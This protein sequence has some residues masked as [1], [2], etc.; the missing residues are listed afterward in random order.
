MSKSL[1]KF[2]ILA[3]SALITSCTREAEN[4]VPAPVPESRT[5]YYKATVQTEVDTRATLGN[6]FSYRFETGDRVYME[7][8]DGNMYGFLSM[9]D[10]E[11]VGENQ[12]VFEGKLTCVGNY[13]PS[14]DTAVK[15]VLVS[16]DDELHTITN[17]K[18]DEVNYPQNKWA[19]SLEE[20]VLHLSHFTGS[21]I[22]GATQFS[23]NQQSC[24]L[25][26]NIRIKSAEAPVNSTV[27]ASL[28]NNQS[29]TPL[30]TASIT[31]QTAGSA[32]FVF[33]FQGGETSLSD[34]VLH[35]EWGDSEKSFDIKDKA[36]AANN[37]YSVF[38]DTREYRGFH[39]RAKN[40]GTN[41]T[42]KYTDG[43]IEYSEDFGDNWTKY[44]GKT[45]QLNA[46][47]VV[48]FRGNRT[49]CNCKGGTQLFTANDIC[50]I[51]G[52]IASLLGYP[53]TLPANAFRSAFSF[54]EISD[55]YAENSEKNLPVATGTVNWVDIDSGDPLILPATTGANCYMEM[56]LGC[57][58]LKTAPDLPAT[59]LADKCYFRMFYGCSSLTSIPTLPSVVTW[60]GTSNRQRYCFQM[61]QYCTGIKKLEEALF[62]G[63]MTLAPNCFEDMFA[64][65]TG[66]TSVIPGLLPATTLA[67]HCY[68]GMFQDTRFERAPDL[69]AT[70][71]VECCYRYMFNG[72]TKLK[73]I[74]CL[75][76][77]PAPNNQNDASTKDWVGNIS[78]SGTFI[79]NN[80]DAM[81]KSWV[82]GA[83]YGIPSGWTAYQVKD[84][85]E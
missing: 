64:H 12:A 52:E 60:N 50:Y 1:F 56:F 25:N 46:N 71:L 8:E 24:F 58:K 51:A 14:Y 49:D 21:G 66:L 83:V 34:A 22:F 33:A 27:T 82:T 38:R 13:T 7:S 18:V 3:V 80:D 68:R 73:Y 16:P 63:T 55:S 5:I 61:F 59:V 35:V 9:S 15:L 69:L 67:K 77:N 20:A 2:L 53:E 78:T 85:P 23:L 70:T 74:K 43:S 26:F 44:K 57:T 37:Y 32:P 48:C 40:D 54:G 6:D 36:L 11:G 79:K 28:Y 10:D 45:F 41:V 65:C 31:V 76:T 84:E 81:T 30:R 19:S 29:D 17:G 72:C 62:G 39:I 4:S 75:A 42:F 47:D